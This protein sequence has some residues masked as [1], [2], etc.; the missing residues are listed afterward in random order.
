MTQERRLHPAGPDVLGRLAAAIGASAVVPADAR[1]LE[2]P[3]GRYR[4]RAAAI[5]RPSCTDEVAAIVRICADARV[6]LVPYGGGTGLVGGQISEDE[7]GRLLV[8]SFERMK[9][10]RALDRTDNVLVAEAGVILADAQ[11][12]ARA[13]DR[14]LPL[15]LASEGTAQIGGLLAT[16]AGGLNVLRYGNARDICLGIEAVMADGTVCHGLRALLKNNMG[17]DLRH[18]LVGA[19]GTLGLIT[20]ASLRLY[21]VP[22]ETAT[23][24]MAV[25]T[26]DAAL[27]L[28]AFARDRMGSTISAFE[29]MHADGFDFL[30][31]TMPQ[32]ACPPRFE[33]D[34]VVLAE[35]EDGLGGALE[36]RFGGLLE[37]ALEAGLV[38]D[39]LIAQSEAQRQSFWMVRESIPEANRRIGSISSHDVSV[40]PSR[41]VEFLDRA[42]PAVAALDPEIRVNCF[43][44]LGDGNLHYNVFPPR[45]RDRAEFDPIRG[46]IKTIVHDLVHGLGGSVAAEHGVGRLKVS[47]LVKYGDP[48]ELAAMR[49]IK[50]ALDPLGILNPGAVLAAD[51]RPGGC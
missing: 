20:A 16:N 22:R 43:G 32:I 19:E 40:P 27:D 25:A 11:A 26:A 30:A 9:R 8:I 17:Y 34:W 14:L 37:A 23:A 48:A 45:G 41:M 39:G 6:G 15:S 21:P 50:A 28:L 4:G 51:E 42:G 13:Q 1:Y 46:K 3:R 35:V 10:I 47:D 31:E 12:A 36:E 18:L 44:H 33:T 49:R 7:D 24:W 2:E 29:L 38:S 5:L